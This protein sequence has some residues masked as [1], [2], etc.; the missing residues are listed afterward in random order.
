MRVI[1]HNGYIS[2]RKRRARWMAF[3]GFL[4]LTSTLWIALN[5]ALLLPAYIAM[6][7]GFIIFN[8]GM[9]QVGKW[10]RN[11]RNDQFLDALLRDKLS[12]KF[13]LVHFPPIGKR[14]TEHLLWHPGGLMAITMREIDGTIIERGRRWS[15]KG[16]GLRRLLAFSGPQLGHPGDD[17]D[18]SIKEVEGYLGERQLEFEVGGVVVFFH[19]SVELDIEDPEYPVLL[20]DELSSFL[21][22]L[23]PDTS[24]TTAE[25]EAFLQPLTE[26]VDVEVPKVEGRRRP[27]R[28]K[29][30]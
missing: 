20:G 19:P 26:G 8:I 5:P 14:K 27:V 11:P 2:S 13:V 30:A 3:L 12:D 15:R 16:I 25:R 6:F 28:R 29:A 17:T 21:N 4:I 23:E 18:Q 24:I 9:Q 10:S 22:S 1:R 7:A